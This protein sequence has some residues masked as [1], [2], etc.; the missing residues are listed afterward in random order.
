MHE[1][2]TVR[3]FR[4]VQKEGNRQI[5]LEVTYYNLDVIP[6]VGYRVRT[7]QDTLFVYGLPKCYGN[8]LL[9]GSH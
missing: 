1:T 6:A 7:V 3:K 2:A 9:K 8:I 4:I 5:E